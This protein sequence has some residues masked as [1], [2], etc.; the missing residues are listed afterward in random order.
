MII[1]KENVKFSPVNSTKSLYAW[2]IFNVNRSH[3]EISETFLVTC[4]PQ[5]IQ[6]ALEAEDL[7]K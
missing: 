1:I 5:T 7:N 2:K 4:E 3:F 6:K